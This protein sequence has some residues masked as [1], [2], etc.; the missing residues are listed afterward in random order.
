LSGGRDSDVI[1]LL[2]RLAG[3]ERLDARVR[4]QLR[5]TVMFVLVA[6]LL[7][8]GGGERAPR[9]RFGPPASWAT[10]RRAT[11]PYRGSLTG[12]RPRG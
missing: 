8:G 1:A 2:W 4:E 7:A 12:R 3:S 9:G 6:Q 10:P 5:A 11:P